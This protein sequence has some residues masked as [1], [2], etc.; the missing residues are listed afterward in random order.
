MRH[1]PSP[2]LLLRLLFLALV[3]PLPLPAQLPAGGLLV[4]SRHTDQVLLYDAGGAFV[5]V[6]AQG[7]GLDN[8]VGLTFGPNGD[9]FVVSAVTNA[10]LRFDGQS[11]VFV[12]AFVG[13][14]VLAAPR[15]LTFGPD[16]DLYVCNAG[17]NSVL[18]F[19]GTSGA[20]MGTAAQGGGL[21]TPTSLAFGPTGDLFVGNVSDSRVHR[22]E[23]GTGRSLGVFASQHIAGAHDLT[24]GP[25]GSLYVSNAF[26]LPSVVR[27]HGFSGAPLG[28][29]V[30]DGAM[31][32]PLG[33]T[34][35]PDGDLYVANQGGHDV[36]RFDGRTGARVGVHVAARSG[37]LNGPLFCVFVPAANL[38]VAAPKPGVAGSHSVLGIRGAVPGAV[39]VLLLGT[40]PGTSPSP[41]PSAALHMVDPNVLAFG[42]ADEAGSSVFWAHVPAAVA[43][44]PFLF[45]AIDFRPCRVSPVMTW[46]F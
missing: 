33:L 46:R 38:Q 23:R 4:T 12:S 14:G 9:L 3:V 45:Q 7:G 21:R 8:P 26:G 22:F 42:I 40:M 11:G 44:F 2:H 39:T 34:F 43:G 30:T 25:G 32:A 20:L 13:P 5:R 36:R 6:F 35:G 41:C 15:N 29:F 24:F 16:G 10:V 17:T 27:F 18:R 31:G 19:D 28:A 1:R 37:G